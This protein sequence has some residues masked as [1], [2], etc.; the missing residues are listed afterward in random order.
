MHP[1]TPLI[2]AIWSSSKHAG[3]VK[4]PHLDV[5]EQQAPGIKMEWVRRMN[6]VGEEEDGGGG[7][8]HKV[9]GSGMCHPHILAALLLI[10]FS[11]DQLWSQYIKHERE[12]GVWMPV[13]LIILAAIWHHFPCYVEMS[14]ASLIC[15]LLPLWPLFYVFDEGLPMIRPF[16]PLLLLLWQTEWGQLYIC[17]VTTALAVMKWFKGI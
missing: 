6:E 14:I 1:A 10:N 7:G 13:H 4:I 2:P 17:A 11:Q 15:L 16:L 9:V 8:R 5:G 12:S 3:D